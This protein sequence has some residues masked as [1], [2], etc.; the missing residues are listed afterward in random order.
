MF[1]TTSPPLG[2]YKIAD[3]L[4]NGFWGA[5]FADCGR[6]TGKPEFTPGTAS[7]NSLTGI[8]W[9]RTIHLNTSSVRG[10]RSR[11][12]VGPFADPD[13]ENSHPFSRIIRRHNWRAR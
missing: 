2:G 12:R 9:S 13:E 5:A 3:A 6:V 7:M 4:I 10:L 8:V 1:P 11:R